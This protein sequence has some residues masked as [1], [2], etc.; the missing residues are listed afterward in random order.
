MD[1]NK[2]LIGGAVVVLGGAIAAGVIL[3]SFDASSSKKKLDDDVSQSQD[4]EEQIFKDFANEDRYYFCQSREE[5]KGPFTSSVFGSE[6]GDIEYIS[7]DINVFDKEKNKLF[8]LGREIKYKYF[9]RGEVQYDIG[10]GIIDINEEGATVEYYNIFNAPIRIDYGAKIIYPAPER[11]KNDWVV[12]ERKG[13]GTM[14]GFTQE[15]V[16]KSM[17]DAKTFCSPFPLK[18]AIITSE[19]ISFEN[20]CDNGAD[21]GFRF[22]GNFKFECGGIDNEKAI[23]NLRELKLRY[24]AR[25]M[26]DGSSNNDDSETNEFQDIIEEEQ[27]DDRDL[28]KKLQQIRD[29]MTEEGIKTDGPI[30]NFTE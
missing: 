7:E 19:Y 30:N 22:S 23:E 27:P 4:I 28:Q 12:I 5:I 21:G 15:D 14:M 2:L 20:S 11:K 10:E 9:G 8:I 17:G 1:R 3:N 13:R 18:N 26:L 16:D 6:S 29:E 25:E 24:E